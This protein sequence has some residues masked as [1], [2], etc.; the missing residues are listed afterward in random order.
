MRSRRCSGAILVNNDAY[1]R[2]SDFLEADAFLRGPAP[3]HLRGG[4]EP[5]QGRQGR[6]PDHPEDLPGRPG[7]RRRHGLPISR[8][9]RRRGHDGHQRGGLRP[10]DL[11]PRHPAAPDRHRRGHG[12]RRLRRAGRDRRR[13]TRSRRPSGGSTSSPRR[14]ATTAA[15]S[16]SPR[17]SPAP[18]TWRP[19][20]SSASGRPLGHLDRP[21]RHGPHDGRP[22]AVRPRDPRRPPGHGQDRARHQH[23]LQH[24]QGL[25]GRR[26][27]RTGR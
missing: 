14:A 3:A 12:Q 21:H 20:P 26:S 15:S 25:R 24:R 4:D 27:S 10:R 5:D 1:Y 19:R 6:D 16:A 9:P 23:R 13:A 18:S 2:V 22:A 8:P 7:S 11:R 17:R